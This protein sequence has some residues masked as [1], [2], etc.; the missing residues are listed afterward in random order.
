MLTDILLPFPS[1][2]YRANPVFSEMCGTGSTC[3]TPG[4]YAMVGAAA[5]LGGVTRMTSKLHT[6]HLITPTIQGLPH[7]LTL[8]I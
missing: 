7:P 5:A 8:A 4:L 2:F 1:S 3:V 6:I